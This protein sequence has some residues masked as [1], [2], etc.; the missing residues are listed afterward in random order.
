MNKPFKIAIIGGTGKVG[1]RIATKAL[2]SGYQVRMLV[3]DT[4]KVVIRDNGIKIVEGNVLNPKDI[5]KTLEGCQV[6]INTFGQ[7]LKGKQIY[8]SVTETILEKMAEL[9]IERYIGVTGGSLTIDGDKKTLINKV[10]TRIFEI[11]FS[12]MMKDKKREWHFL[13]SNNLIEKW[14]LIRLPFI[15]DQEEIGHLKENLKD[16][17]GTKITNGDIATFIINQI[18][19][20]EVCTKS[21]IYFKLIVYRSFI[22]LLSA[23]SLTWEKKL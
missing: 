6:V 14:T 22:L 5:Q 16:M 12:N 2:E 4:K 23:I 10:G 8:S 17:P 9:Q 7:S 1:R 20:F 13:S 3:R 19:R 15:V 11:I 18:E 21:T